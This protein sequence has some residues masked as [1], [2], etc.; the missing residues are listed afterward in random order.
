MDLNDTVIVTL[1]A[2][3]AEILN[4]INEEMARRVPKHNWKR[5]YKEGDDYKAP[6]WSMFEDFGAHCSVGTVHC[7]LNLRLKSAEYG[8]KTI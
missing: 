7:F 5:D 1:T 8:S 4:E 3:G 6:L 2:K